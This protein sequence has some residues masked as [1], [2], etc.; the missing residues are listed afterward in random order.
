MDSPQT[1]ISDFASACSVY[2]KKIC[3]NK[4]HKH[5]IKNEKKLVPFIVIRH[6]CVADF[7]DPEQSMFTQNSIMTS[8]TLSYCHFSIL[9][10]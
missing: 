10:A 7:S 1:A 2:L 6:A 8:S 4:I 3:E 5:E 9:H